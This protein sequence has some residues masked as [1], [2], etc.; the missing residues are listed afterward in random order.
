MQSLLDILLTKF[1]QVFDMHHNL[2]FGDFMFTRR[3]AF[4]QLQIGIAMA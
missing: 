3:Q 1:I 2:F 4:R